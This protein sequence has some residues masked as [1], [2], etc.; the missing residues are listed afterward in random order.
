MS[1]RRRIAVRSELVKEFLVDRLVQRVVAALDEELPNGTETVL[2]A[3]L[4]NGSDAAVEVARTLARHGYQARVA[5]TDLFE[6]ARL[7]TPELAEIVEESG[8][9]AASHRLA[10]E[11]PL[12]LPMPDAEGWTSWRV[13][14]P[15]GH[16]RHF[17]AT[18][19]IRRALGGRPAPDRLDGRALKR[20]WFYGFYVR[21]C[22]EVGSSPPI[23]RS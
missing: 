17:V 18:E 10:A 1:E 6:P 2:D 13:P 12:E 19:C 20:C 9:D 21:C 23:P 11:E 8:A 7:P 4:D 5:E 16:V 15:G 22:E 14:G 3:V